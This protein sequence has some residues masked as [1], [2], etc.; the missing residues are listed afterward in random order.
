MDKKK[1]LGLFRG[2]ALLCVIAT[3]ILA[4]GCATLPAEPEVW[5]PGLT[6]PSS[7]ISTEEST[8]ATTEA[9]TEPSISPTTEPSTEPSAEPTTEPSQAPTAEPTV[10]PTQGP[11]E[12]ESSFEIHFIDVGQADAALVIC[13]GKTMLIDGGNADDSNLMYAY[14]KKLNIKHLDY[15]I[16]THAHEDH[17]GGIAGALNYASVGI[18]YC[19]STSYSTNAFRNFVNALN[20]HGVSITVPTPGL[21]FQ[22]GSAT[23]TILAVNTDKADVNNTSIV[24]RIVYGE[25]TFLF[26]GDAEREVEQVLLDRG[27]DLSATV[28]K[29]GHHGSRSSTSYVFLREIMP[30]YAVICVGKGNT[31]G[32]PTSDVLSR[33]RDAD[34]TTF[35]TDMQGDILCVSDGTKVT[36]TVSKNANADVFGNLN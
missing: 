3:L 24:M 26:V 7:T 18:A 29:V 21:T 22:L 20:K 33:L 27:V 25:T 15:V 30:E 2:T 17:I 12:P 5:A 16:G 4:L 11:T 28:L 23:C 13:D 32:H 9:T 8:G 14:L 31:Y 1:L 6:E 10:P 36:F 35:R 34:V 19:P